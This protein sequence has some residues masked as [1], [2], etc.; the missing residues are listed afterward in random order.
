MKTPRPVRTRAP[1]S[2]DAYAGFL[3]L[4]LT[5]ADRQPRPNA[6]LNAYMRYLNA[7][8]P[9]PERVRRLLGTVSDHAA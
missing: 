2:A 7:H 5:P 3:R 4:W 9:L 6:E 1:M 8:A